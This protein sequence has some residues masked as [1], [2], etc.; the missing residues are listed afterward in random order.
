MRRS[1]ILQLAS[2]HGAKPMHVMH[3]FHVSSSRTSVFF[4]EDGFAVH[5]DARGK[6]RKRPYYKGVEL[7]WGKEWSY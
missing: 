4:H 6:N 3:G 5:K 1:R 2:F 7:L